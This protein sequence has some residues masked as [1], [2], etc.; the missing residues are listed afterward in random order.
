M[1]GAIPNICASIQKTVEDLNHKRIR[2][3]CLLLDL[4]ADEYVFRI[5]G[6]GNYLVL[7]HVDKLPGKLP[8]LYISMTK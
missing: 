6:Q 4:Y 1:M 5:F 7:D 8:Q 3:F 2:T